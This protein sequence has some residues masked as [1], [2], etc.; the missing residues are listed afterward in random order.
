M[1]DPKSQIQDY[2]I[3][4]NDL[5]IAVQNATNAS[6]NIPRKVDAGI[7]LLDLAFDLSG[8]KRQAKS[9]GTLLMENQARNQIIQSEEQYSLWSAKVIEFLG[10]ISV[11]KTH[12]PKDGNS[13]SILSSFSNTMKYVKIITKLNHGI[14]F[15]ETLRHKDLINNDKISEYL[16]QRKKQEKVKKK[17]EMIIESAPKPFSIQHDIWEMLDAYPNEKSALM[18]AVFIYQSES[19]DANRQALSSCRN[20]LEMLIKKISGKQDWNDGL[21]TIFQSSQKRKTIKST[22]Q[23]LSA[24]GVHGPS[25]PSEGDT[26]MGIE[27][28]TTAIKWIL[29]CAKDSNII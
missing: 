5:L 4:G 19:P 12:L 9:V 10:T 3:Q 25:Q 21:L 16:K 18:G 7:T 17:A 22:F 15:L 14:S 8:H 28:T 27:M 29:I 20:A 6:K 11:I 1:R 23:Y 13:E 26:E 24:Y 2:I